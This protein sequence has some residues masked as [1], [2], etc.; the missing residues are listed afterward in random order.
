MSAVAYKARRILSQKILVR[1]PTR[2]RLV[3]S[4]GLHVFAPPDLW[5][6]D[7]L[8]SH[9]VKLLRH[10]PLLAMDSQ[11]SDS[12]EVWAWESDFWLNIGDKNQKWLYAFINSSIMWW[13]ELQWRCESHVYL[14]SSLY[15][16][17]SA[18][19]NWAC[20]FHWNRTSMV[21]VCCIHHCW[22]CK[23]ST[24]AA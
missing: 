14:L 3:L 9:G 22:S 18:Q 5:V 19:S 6:V 4:S 7:V 16:H 15:L 12:L 1:H 10:L 24:V 17:V 13:Q 2:L 8:F 11:S 21:H 23:L 20:K